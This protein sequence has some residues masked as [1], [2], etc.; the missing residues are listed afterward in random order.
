MK[1]ADYLPERKTKIYLKARPTVE[2]GDIAALR[3]ENSELA[4]QFN[5]AQA[6][7]K[8][9][10]Y[11][12]KST[13]EEV[14]M[15]KQLVSP[16]EYQ[17]TVE[18]FSTRLNA[19][20]VDNTATIVKLHK[21][22]MEAADVNLEA[23]SSVL[24]EVSFQLEATKK[25]QKEL[26]NKLADINEHLK[27]ITKK[28]QNTALVD[29]LSLFKEQL[30]TLS[31]LLKVKIRDSQ[32]E[33]EKHKNYML[34]LDNQKYEELDRLRQRVLKLEIERPFAVSSFDYA[35]TTKQGI[36]NNGNLGNLYPNLVKVKD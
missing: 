1:L 6:A 29:E 34:D 2:M 33:I 13:K 18:E 23:F 26:D 24:N 17:R 22:S 30:N 10:E 12:Y 9:L 27:A 25:E 4:F 35:L 21:S 7:Y 15:L 31:T 36:L 16:S 19:A 3:A 32:V 8:K 28:L 11:A 5:A 20:V 14:Q